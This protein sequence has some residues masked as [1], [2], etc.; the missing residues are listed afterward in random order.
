MC[1]RPLLLNED[2]LTSQGEKEMK[3]DSSF[4][5]DRSLFGVSVA[6][7]RRKYKRTA[8]A[9]SPLC[10]CVCVRACFTLYTRYSVYFGPCLEDQSYGKA[11]VTRKL[12]GTF[13]SF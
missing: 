12:D 1:S 2:H 5:S 7:Y 8:A 13:S 9:G 3:I 6:S 4:T 10:V 11:V